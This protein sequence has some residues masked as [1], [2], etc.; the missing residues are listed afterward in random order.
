MATIVEAPMDSIVGTLEVPAM[1]VV[2]LAMH[3]EHLALVHVATTAP[4][5]TLRTSMIL[6]LEAVMVDTETSRLDMIITSTATE[7]ADLRQGI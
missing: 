5:G 4:R 3:L 7:E 2:V 6:G 1:V